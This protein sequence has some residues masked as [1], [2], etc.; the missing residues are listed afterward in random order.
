MKYSELENLLACLERSARVNPSILSGNAA[1]GVYRDANN[2]LLQQFFALDNSLL[3]SNADV[4][5]PL[6]ITIGVNYT[7]GSSPKPP[8]LPQH[9]KLPTKNKFALTALPVSDDLS[10]ER[11]LLEICMVDYIQ[12]YQ[13]WHDNGN[14][15][16][17]TLDFSDLFSRKTDTSLP[18]HMVMTNL[19]GWITTESWSNIWET[20]GR[21]ATTEFV[22]A[23]FLPS[24][25]MHL[26]ELKEQ[27]LESP[28]LWVAH[29]LDSEAPPLARRF[30]AKH[31]I[32][33][34]MITPNLGNWINPKIGTVHHG[35]LEILKFGEKN[36]RRL[37]PNFVPEI[38]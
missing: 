34:W 22:S 8:K 23:G 33:N 20:V 19:C 38:L 24:S 3:K 26:D 6:V 1:K 5:Y 29:G 9:P 32:R 37:S 35:S 30:F 36:K 2:F 16:S 15:S 7:Q 12:R 21:M 31:N 13:V 4:D 11:R 18:F 27:L 17:A 28:V 14:A 25:F 10:A